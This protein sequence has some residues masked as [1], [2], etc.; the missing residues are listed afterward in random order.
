MMPRILLLSLLL[1]TSL[2]LA[3]D[4]RAIFAAQCQ[5]CHGDGHGTERG[6]NLAD[7]RRV[8]AQS[9][10][11][12][13]AVIRDGIPAS[14]MPAFNLPAGELG[15]VADFVRS[16]SAPAIDSV[17][18]GDRATG[19]QLFFGNA[20]CAN[21]H[22]VFGRG[23]AVGP[24]LSSLGRQ[25]TVDAIRQAILNPSANIK[26]GY[27]AVTVQL[28]NGDTLRGFARNES[29]YNI[30]LQDFAGGFHFLS[31]DEY[32]VASREPRSLM[33]E[34][35]CTGTDCDNLVAYLSSLG[36]VDVDTDPFP[37]ES[38]GARHS[39]MSRAPR[40]ATGQLITAPSAA[41]VTA[42]STKSPLL[43]SIHWR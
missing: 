32:E 36:G 34:G 6:P 17:V 37:F 29:R 16:L 40:A 9:R 8:R 31:G 23:K 28:A 11:Q 41:T 3:Q 5:A 43:T 1:G 13:L 38:V 19:E 26:K 2:A 35:K 14:G 33:P 22:M 39:K 15:A 10:E 4:G 25:L 20:G 21:C 42:S 24:D 12:L 18:T 30:Q 7:N 27:E